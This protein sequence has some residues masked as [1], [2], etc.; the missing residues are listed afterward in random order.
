M[1]VRSA[2]D[3]SLERVLLRITS[4]MPGL[5][6][7]SECLIYDEGSFGLSKFKVSRRAN[8]AASRASRSLQTKLQTNCAT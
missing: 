6:G 8:T 1:K 3:V 4:A 2:K 7:T 5:P